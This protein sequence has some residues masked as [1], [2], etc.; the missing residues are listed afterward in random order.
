M[1]GVRPSCPTSRTGDEVVSSLGPFQTSA[2]RHDRH[3]ASPL[4]VMPSASTPSTSRSAG[5]LQEGQGPR[6]RRAEPPRYDSAPRPCH[7]L[8]EPP[9]ARLEDSRRGPRFSTE[10]L[11]P[12]QGQLAWVP[13]PRPPRVQARRAGEGRLP[14]PTQASAFLSAFQAME[15]A[16]EPNPGALS[17][18]KAS[19]LVAGRPLPWPGRNLWLSRP[20]IAMDLEARSTPQPFLHRAP[21]GMGLALALLAVSLWFGSTRSP[22]R[23]GSWGWRSTRQGCG[24]GD[25]IARGLG[26]RCGEVSGG[27]PSPTGTR[28]SSGLARLGGPALFFEMIFRQTYRR[29]L[30]VP[31]ACAPRDAPGRERAVF[32]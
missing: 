2:T 28:R 3:R 23:P 20:T 4:L 5:S 15:K 13:L 7:L 19:A 18:S 1:G 6:G 8:Q 17:E 32:A 22:P 12:G 25:R 29:A 14:P 24:P 11:R 16:E 10:V 9:P 26:S 31:E 21:Y 27:R 30:A